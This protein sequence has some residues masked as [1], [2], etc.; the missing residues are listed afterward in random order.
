MMQDN[1]M[2]DGRVIRELFNVPEGDDIATLKRKAMKALRDK[3]VVKFSQRMVG[4]NE[5]CP[6]GSG[7]KFKK[8]CMGQEWKK[9]VISGEKAAG[10]AGA[11]KL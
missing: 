7:V 6:C 11:T 3:N 9:E 1:T 10:K 4:R 5:P 8:C 2:T